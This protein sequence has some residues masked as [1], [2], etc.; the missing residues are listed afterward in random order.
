LRRYHRQML[1]INQFIGGDLPYNVYPHHFYVP[2]T[3][4]YAF[5]KLDKNRIVAYIY[6]RESVC[7]TFNE[8]GLRRDVKSSAEYRFPV[9]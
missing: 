4:T 2:K 6:R 7:L 5:D 1:A 9:K 8:N 3:L